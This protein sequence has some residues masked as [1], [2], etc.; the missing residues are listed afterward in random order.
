[1]RQFDDLMIEYLTT[2]VLATESTK[3]TEINLEGIAD[4]KN[5]LIPIDVGRQQKN[6]A[7]S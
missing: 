4:D 6:Y 3:S 2:K 1:M 5:N 7:E